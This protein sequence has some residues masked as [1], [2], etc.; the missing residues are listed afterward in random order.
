MKIIELLNT[1]PVLEQLMDRKMP[2]QLAY[3]LAKNY[4]LITQELETIDKARI[5]LLKAHWSLDEKT[6]R[7]NIPNEDQLKWKEMYD[8]LINGEADYK[9]YKVNFALTEKIEMTPGEIMSLW[10]IFDNL[11][12]GPAPEAI[13]PDPAPK[14]SPL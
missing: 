8:E 1:G 12:L 5:N 13:A 11:D 3:A 10:F 6:N 2:T 7:Y 4:R 14:L 9:P